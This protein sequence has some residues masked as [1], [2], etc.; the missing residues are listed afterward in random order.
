MNRHVRV[1][2]R[3]GDRQRSMVRKLAKY[4]PPPSSRF[5]R[6][7]ARASVADRITWAASDF[8][9]ERM[10]FRQRHPVRCGGVTCRSSVPHLWVTVAGI[11]FPDGE[12]A[13]G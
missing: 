12:Q 6:P 5:R 10:Q 4:S 13:N 8:V 7:G 3:A 9:R 1:S 11:P 2:A